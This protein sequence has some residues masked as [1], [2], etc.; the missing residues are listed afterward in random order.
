MQAVFDNDI[1]LK[2]AIYGL[3]PD[4]VKVLC[5]AHE[6]VGILGAAKFVVSSRIQ[7]RVQSAR[8]PFAL[9]AL[10]AF[11]R[12]ALVVEP[13]ADEQM[14]AAELELV[15]QRTGLSLDAGE[16]QLCAIVIH[17]G[18]PLLVSGDKRAIIALDKLLDTEKRM[19]SILGKVKCL[20]QLIAVIL[21][22]RGS[23]RLRNAI[24]SEPDIDKALSNCFSCNSQEVLE[25]S[26]LEGLNSYIS[27]IRADASRV[28]AP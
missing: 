12:G 22:E 26:F 7:R 27:A 14:I 16:S 28:L 3:L 9:E 23:A 8:H 11:L 19:H 2:G 20:E 1:V 10:A 24:C 13:S 18:V 21:T 15:A 5:Q 6:T 4:F 25:G 17:R